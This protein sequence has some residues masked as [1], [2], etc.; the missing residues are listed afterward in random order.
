VDHNNELL[1]VHEAA[2]RL[3]RS[4]EQVR[5]YLRE[6]KLPGRRIGGQWFIQ[7]EAL[8]AYPRE[9]TQEAHLGEVA[10][11]DYRA[12]S[13][14]VDTLIARINANRE[15]IRARL[16]GNVPIDVVELIREDREEH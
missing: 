15:A 9:R 11:M 3:R 1:T 7:E 16:G 10:V 5:R 4:T 12:G 13:S 8:A 6:G 14:T 2:L